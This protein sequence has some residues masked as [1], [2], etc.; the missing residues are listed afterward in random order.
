MADEDDEVKVEQSDVDPQLS[1]RIQSK[2]EG[3]DLEGSKMEGGQSEVSRASRK[4]PHSATSKKR[5]NLRYSNHDVDEDEVSFDDNL[6]APGGARFGQASSGMGVVQQSGA[7]LINSS[8]NSDFKL[9]RQHAYLSG[10]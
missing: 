4:S 8:K 9:N 2:F 10:E 3:G 5:T 6:A 1:P 7:F